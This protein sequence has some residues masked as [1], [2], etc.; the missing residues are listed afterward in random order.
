MTRRGCGQD[1]SAVTA[2]SAP[3][4]FYHRNSLDSEQSGDVLNHEAKAGIQRVG[5]VRD[6][7]SGFWTP[8]PR[9]HEDKLRGGD[10][11]AGRPLVRLGVQ[12]KR[13][14][15]VVHVLLGLAKDLEVVPALRVG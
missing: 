7:A 13:D 9:F 2:I 4:A 5:A 1:A 12:R 14:R 8:A 3:F 10:D 11:S 6:P 15:V